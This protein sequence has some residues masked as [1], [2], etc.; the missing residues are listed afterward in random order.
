MNSLSK[1]SLALLAASLSACGTIYP[2]PRVELQ[3]MPVVNLPPLPVAA[4][5]NGSIYQAVSY[6]PL[7]EDHRAR[8]VGDTL[9]VQIV[10]KISA[11]Q[12]STSA[13][14]KTGSIAG[15]VTAIP[16]VSP[17]AFA[18]AS[19]AGTSATKSAGKGSNE[20]TNDFSG[21]ITAIV[22]AVLPNGHLMISGEKQIGVNH[23]VDVLRFSGQVDPR[24]IVQG[25]TVPSAS[26]ANV[27]IEQRGRGAT[28]DAHGIGWLSRFFLNLSPT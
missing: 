6:R 16:F 10:E 2:E 23:N 26:I 15:N 25:N 20:N 28:S 4:P 21:S 3:H 18:R 17:G 13:I 19:A 22:T 5:S 24:A 27:R 8:L 12:S 14:D 1:L 7:F 9:T 11:S